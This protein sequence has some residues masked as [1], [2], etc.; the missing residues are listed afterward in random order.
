[1]TH[2]AAP[3]T[4]RPPAV[5]GT[6]YADDP[7]ALRQSVTALVDA[8]RRGRAHNAPVP[9]AIIAPHAG[10]VYSGAVAAQAYVRLE[11]ARDRLR[12]I[13]LVGPT[14]RVPVAGLALSGAAAWHTPLGDIRLDQA[15]A[16]ARLERL[17]D[18]T[19]YDKAHAAEHS[20]EV[21][22][23]FLQCV[24]DAVALVPLVIGR[25]DP[26]Q[27]A[28]ALDAL[29]GGPETAVVISSDLSHFLDYETCQRKDAGTAAAIES[30]DPT[31]IGPHEA[32]GCA[33][34]NG[35]LALAR[36][37]GL[38]VDRLD[39][40]NSG[41]TAGSRD[42]VVGYGAWAFHETDPP[43]Q[44][45]G[46]IAAGAASGEVAANADDPVAATEALV[47]EHGAELLRLAATSLEHGTL[48]GRPRPVDLTHEPPPL[49]APG[50]AFVTLTRAQDDALRGCIGSVEA[51]RPLARDVAEHGFNAG[52]RDSRFPP[53]DHDELAGLRLSVSV[54]TPP[55]PM[56]VTDRD[57]LLARMQPGVDGLILEDQG[58]RGVFLP[59]VWEQLPTPEAFLT[60]LM[61]K[62]GL[63]DTHWSTTIRIARF[64][65]RGIKAVPW[66]TAGAA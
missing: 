29:W 39:V 31:A 43:K 32:C 21:H 12:R 33:A 66:A 50:A 3:A 23:P 34:V 17:A 65:T 30:L 8:A 16:R 56:P 47:R 27:A 20:L 40:R 1:M 59:Q 38:R 49:Q 41:D 58:R 36:Q 2:A 22:L 63:P 46:H 44:G 37:R 60:H 26:A 54:L 7:D 53:V 11:P 35:L 24:L 6:F 48:Y 61:R 19:V 14:H 64:E 10:H 18:V 57:D 5:A 62:A 55:M 9:K 42:R 52:F 45:A 25:C 13:V 28:R 4:I 51:R 15:W